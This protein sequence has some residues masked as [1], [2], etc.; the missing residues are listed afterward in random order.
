MPRRVLI[1][2]NDP[3]LTYVLN[4]ALGSEGYQTVVARHGAAALTLLADSEPPD[5]IITELEMPLVSGWELLEA[6]QR[7]PRL[8]GIAT[9]ALVGNV[10]RGAA[11]IAT[12]T[13]S[14]PF[15]IEDLIRLVESTLADVSGPVRIGDQSAGR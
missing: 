2:E 12:A 1:V 5:L 15:G 3:A 10:G 14:K 6:C 7:D 11:P 13:L 9:I 4:L 8:E